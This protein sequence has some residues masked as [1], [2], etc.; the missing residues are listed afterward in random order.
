MNGSECHLALFGSSKIAKG[1]CTFMRE[2]GR[3]QKYNKRIRFVFIDLDIN[4][5][6]QDVRGQ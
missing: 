3:S 6:F 2:N 4:I 5:V 1:I